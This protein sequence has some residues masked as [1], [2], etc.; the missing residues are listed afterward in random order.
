MSKLLEATVAVKPIKD[1]QTLFIGGFM[2]V[3][4]PHH[5]IK[6]L[7]ETSVR[8]LTVIAN[9]SGT[10]DTGIGLLVQQRRLNKIVASHIGLNPETGRLM[11]SGELEV[12]LVPQGTLVEAIRAG[13]AG[14]G[15]FLTPTGVGTVVETDKQVITI[16]GKD[17][18]LELPLRAN[19]ALIKAYKADTAGNLIFRKAARNF[20]PI[21]ATAANYVVAEVEEVVA[22][23]DIDPD[24]V[25]LPGIFVDAI[26]KG[27]EAN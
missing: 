20:N 10:P 15:G 17:Y 6:A 21:M 23:G 7:L 9:D 19:V 16:E 12:E 4:S 24:Q 1:G 8:Q 25:M 26:V 3:G 13:G 18:L 27:G 22:V 11:H 5:L 14:L 2:S